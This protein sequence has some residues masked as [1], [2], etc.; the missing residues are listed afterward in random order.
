MKRKEKKSYRY[1]RAPNINM[2]FMKAGY[3]GVSIE[4]QDMLNTRISSSTEQISYCV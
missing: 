2:N 4:W 1:R 3:E